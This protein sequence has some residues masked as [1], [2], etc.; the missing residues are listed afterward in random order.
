M[1]M[2]WKALPALSLAAAI[3]CQAQPEPTSSAVG[4]QSVETSSPSAVGEAI[5]L[6]SLKVPN[7]V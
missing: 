7:M 2:T 6:V 5:T 3:G 4:A 1:R